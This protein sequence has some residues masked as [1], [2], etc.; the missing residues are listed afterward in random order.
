[1]PDQPL[2][3]VIVPCYN[4]GAL[5]GEALQSLLDQTYAN[6]ECIVVNDGS[7]DDTANKAMAWINKDSRFKYFYQSNGGLSAARN[8]GLAAI[9]GDYIQFLDADDTIAPG[10]FALSLQEGGDADVIITNFSMFT[11]TGE[12]TFNAAF[13][14]HKDQLNFHSLLTGWDEEFVIPIHCGLFKSNL[15]STLRFNESLKAKEDWLM[16]IQIYQGGIETVFIDEPFALYRYSPGSMSQNRRHMHS[17]LVLA[18]QA[19]YEQLSTEH[20]ELFFKKAVNYLGGLLEETD[21]LLEKTRHSKSYQLGNLFVRNFN[22]LF[23]K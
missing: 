4:Q 16:W 2:I 10:K 6:W 21:L 15:F 22:K 12:S 14:L 3:S 7:S 23:K 9:S 13:T 19:I 1:M 18:Y 5:L 17:N 8:K 20:R 11:K